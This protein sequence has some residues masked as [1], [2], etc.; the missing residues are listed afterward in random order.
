M[1]NRRKL[2]VLPLEDRITPTTLPAGFNEQVVMTGLNNPSCMTVAP[3]GRIFVALQNGEVRIIQDGNMLPTPF[4]D[5]DT[6]GSGEGGLVGFTL[7]PNFQDNG[8]FYTYYLVPGANGS[9]EF[10][11]VSRFTANGNSASINSEQVLLNLDPIVAPAGSYAHNGGAMHFGLDGKLYIATGDNLDPPSAQR[12][13]LFRGKILRI[14]TDGTIPA[15]NPTSFQ[16]VNGSTNGLYRAIY[17]IGLRNPFTFDVQPG[18]GRIFLNDVGQDAWEE[19]NE[20]KPGRNYGWPQTE[21]VTSNPNVTGPVFTYPH[22]FSDDTGLAV[23]GGA[24]YN[25]NLFAFPG[26]YHSD[27]FFAEFVVNYIKNFDPATGQVKMFAKDL[28]RGGVIDLDVT[29][30]GDLYYLARG[31]DGTDS[32]VYRIRYSNQPAIAQQPGGAR[33][34]AGESVT[35]SVQANGAGPLRY[36]WTRNGFDIAGADGPTYTLTAR[37]SDNLASYRVVV[38]NDFGVVVS[39]AAVLTVTS[40]HPPT[41]TITSPSS[42]FRFIAGQT[43]TAEGFGFDPDSGVLPPDALTWKVEYITGDAPPRPF[44]EP[45]TGQGSVSFTI[46]TLT[47]Y[48]LTDVFYRISLTARDDTGLETTTTREI[49]PVKSL[50]T[51]AASSSEASVL[52]DGQPVGQIHSFDAVAGLERQIAVPPSIMVDGVVW[53]FVGW[54]DGES[55]PSRV[56]S[57]PA[58]TTT[59]FAIYDQPTDLAPGIAVGAGPGGGPLVRTFGLDG[60]MDD[61]RFAFNANL[62][63]GVSVATADF[64]GDGVPDLAA[65]SGPGE[66]PR[67]TLID[68]ATNVTLKTLTVFEDQFFGGVSVNAAD[69][70]GDHKAELIVTPGYGGGPRV[71]VLRANSG[72]T[73][74]D[75]FGI[76]DVAFRGGARA[77]AGDLNGDGTPDLVVTAGDGGGPRVAGWDGSELLQG[78]YVRRFDDFFAFDS[79]LR[80]GAFISVGDLDGDGHAELI[81][82]AGVGGAP[83][84]VVRNGDG[85]PRTASAESNPAFFAGDFTGRGGIR[86]LARDLNGDGK[87]EIITTTASGGASLVTIYD[88]KGNILEQFEAF[89][90]TIPGGVF[91]G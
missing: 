24:F 76:A 30:N 86:V 89:E 21:G 58:E 57:T 25:P 34:T 17:A 22:G 48:K 56:I 79:D 40:S 37:S 83:E 38:Q 59:Y 75:F 31:E 68:G 50:I 41:A 26:E 54:F 80:G 47:P 23:T 7:D 10:N 63:N 15:D 55:S 74:A 90:G 32:G 27:Y 46:P 16:G 84:V 8:Y 65:G 49:H 45:V 61:E 9:N 5:L 53:P 67:V 43:V 28:T 60:S 33:L 29:S 78:R 64:T 85:L 81:F 14:N 11:R 91:V 35:L 51:V 3:D 82:G 12:L 71:R 52:L 13:D 39:N 36:Q 88:M 66:S 4:I 6:P 62:R 1:K 20:L 72:A 77:A 44:V 70:D 18:T 87:A 69:F 42:D 2:H 73:V 19:I